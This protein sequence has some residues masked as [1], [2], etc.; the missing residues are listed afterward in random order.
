[1]L[2]L[3]V[4]FPRKLCSAPSL[5]ADALG[6]ALQSI[7][8]ASNFSYRFTLIFLGFLLMSK[9]PATNNFQMFLLPSHPLQPVFE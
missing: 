7:S 2:S 3:F 1:M 5:A 6:S 4:L 9:P 8:K